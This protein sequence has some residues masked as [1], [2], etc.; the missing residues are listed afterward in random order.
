MSEAINHLQSA[1]YECFNLVISDIVP[2]ARSL[3]WVSIDSIGS[4]SSC[5]NFSKMILTLWKFAEYNVRNYFNTKLVLARWK[6]IFSFVNSRKDYTVYNISIGILCACISFL[7]FLSFILP[8]WTNVLLF[9]DGE[10]KEIKV[11]QEWPLLNRCKKKEFIT[12]G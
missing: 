9:H 3:A 12:N 11:V 8:S 5:S 4:H 10:N 6:R 7:I 1:R 2:Y